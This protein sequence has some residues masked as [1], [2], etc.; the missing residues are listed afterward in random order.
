MGAAKV[1]DGKLHIDKTLCSN[2]GKCIEKCYF[3][4]FDGGQNGFKLYIG[5][6]WGKKGRPARFL[7]C[8]H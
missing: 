7:P 4:A 6:K 8:T 1:Q 2:C 5:G 3:K